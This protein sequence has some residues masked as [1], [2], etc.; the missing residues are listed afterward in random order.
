MFRIILA[1][2]FTTFQFLSY[3]QNTINII[4]S[5]QS[6]EEPLIGVNVFISSLDKGNTT[7]LNGGCQFNLDSGSYL[8]A[9]SYIGYQSVE[10]ALDVPAQIEYR[11]ELISD[12]KMKLSKSGH[13]PV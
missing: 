3:S 1:I 12:L 11:D 10:L 9:L 8:V 13:P 2:V 7:D 5:D 4:V 6:T